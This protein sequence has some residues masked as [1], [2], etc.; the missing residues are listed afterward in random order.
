MKDLWNV[1]EIA[2]DT[3][4]AQILFTLIEPYTPGGVQDDG[5][6]KNFVDEESKK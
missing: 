3:G 4:K 6:M 2:G 1:L 5:I